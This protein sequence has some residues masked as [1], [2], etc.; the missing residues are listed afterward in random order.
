MLSRKTPLYAIPAAFGLVFVGAG[1]ASAAPSSDTWD[2]LAECESGGDW[3]TNTGNGF[4]GG[5]QFHPDTWASH[6]GSGSAADASRGEQI[7]VA[8]NVL[9]TQGWG[10]WPA[11]SSSMGLSGNTAP[12]GSGSSAPEETPVQEET[13]EQPAE[14]ESYSEPVETYDE[15]QWEE[16]VEEQYYETY[17]E[18][19]VE[20]A[21]VEEAEVYET[22]PAPTPVEGLSGAEHVVAEGETLATIAEDYN[23]EGGFETLAEI[24]NIQDPNLIFVGDVIALP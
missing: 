1:A 9:E 6:G 16:P 19:V 20:E 15:P 5:L 10:A 14:T 18:T 17:D 23:V 2:Q 24:N 7:R 8:E 4:E 21:P 3:G 22:V 12:E 13:Y 11:C